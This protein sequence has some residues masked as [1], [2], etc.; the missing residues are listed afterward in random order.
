MFSK[1]KRL[2]ILNMLIFSLSGCSFNGGQGNN[3]PEG[4]EVIKTVT[5]ITI[6]KSP[7]KVDYIVGETFNPDG[8]AINELFNDSSV[9]DEVKGY[10]YTPTTPLTLAT[11]EITFRYRNFMTTQKIT[12]VEQPDEITRAS[13]IE[14]YDNGRVYI[15]VDGQPFVILGAQL[16][17]D[18]LLNRSPYLPDAPSPLTYAEMEKYFIAA[19]EANFNTIELC[20]QW[21]NI[22]TSKDVYQFELI[23]AL[24]GFLNKHNLKGEINWFS[25]NMCGDTEEYQ[26]PAYV[27][28]DQQTY[29]RLKT[30]VASGYQ[31]MYGERFYLKLDEPAV[32]ER[33]AKAITAL[34]EHIYEWNLLNGQKNPIIGVQVQNETDG[35]VRWRLTQKVIYDTDGVTVIS[36]NKLWNMTLSS[37]NNAGKAFKAS[38]YKLYTRCNITTSYDVKE[39]PQCPNTG[40]G[41]LDILNLDGIDIIGSD[42]YVTSTTTINS[43]VKK[44]RVG[45]NYPHV[46][47]NMGNYSNGPSLFLTTYQ[48]GGSYM[49]YDLATPE[50]FVYMNEQAGSSYQMDQGIYNPDLTLKP[51]SQ[52]TFDIAKGIKAMGGILSRIESKDFAAFNI[53]T[54]D[55][56]QTR[57]QIINTSNLSFEFTTTDGGI[58]FAI[59]DGNYVYMSSNKDCAIGIVNAEYAPYADIGHFE[60]EDFVAEEK[61][62]PTDKLYLSKGKLY[63]IKITK[64]INE[65]TSTTDDNV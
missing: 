9:G 36:P 1:I 39:Y 42:P 43:T 35:L 13:S 32:Q 48:A 54:D 10:T 55:P 22:E 5:G 28:N 45:D 37:L 20:I 59:E 4:P 31:N 64:I 34:M 12:V 61:A 46:A 25:V 60:G 51:H 52:A 17:V 27:F 49:F 6:T 7:N 3:Q 50:Y 65:V 38:K 21:S 63:R 44:Y 53:D 26:V 23:D 41:P 2:A 62:Y 47:E 8:I 30:E 57:T 58:A 24:M 14:K 33:E 56:K 15:K 18:G 16:R 29:P 40:I 19:K 11:K